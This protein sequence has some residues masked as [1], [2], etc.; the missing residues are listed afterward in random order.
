MNLAVTFVDLLV[1]AV[2]LIS[3]VYAAYRG[4]VA[5][6]LSIFA[7]LAAAFATLYFG[8]YAAPLTRNLVTAPCLGNL[9]GYALVFLVVFIPMQFMSHRF[10]LGVKS[11]V[12]GPLDRIMGIAFGLVRG[13]VIL[14][15]AYLAFSLFVPVPRQPLW[16][17]DART[18]PLIQ[19]SSEVLLALL[20]DHG[21]DI[22]RDMGARSS[23]AEIVHP[24]NDPIAREIERTQG[25]RI[26]KKSYGA[27]DRRALD[28]LIEATG[29][30]KP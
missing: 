14:G 24:A 18:L 27:D 13:L 19:S 16:L 12:I 4:F 25:K 26:K 30:G 9:L 6:T 21:A 3:A 1:V 29:N 20:P 5:E 11:S 17:K 28:R 8:H 22:A 23:T 15:V 10:A 7:W 2:V